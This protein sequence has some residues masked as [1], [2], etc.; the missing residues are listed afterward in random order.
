VRL[1][2][3][4]LIIIVAAPAGAVSPYDL[5]FRSESD[6]M[7]MGGGDVPGDITDRPE[8]ERPTSLL[9]VARP[10]VRLDLCSQTP[11]ELS[12][13]TGTL[14]RWRSEVLTL[15]V[16]KPLNERWAVGIQAKTIDDSVWYEDGPDNYRLHS[17]EE[18]YALSGAYRV[19]RRW[20]VGGAYAWGE[21]DGDARGSAL[22]AALDLAPD[23]EQWPR[24]RLD[25]SNLTLAATFDDGRWS[26]GALRGWSDPR[27]TLRVTRDVYNYT[28]PLDQGADW[29]EIWAGYREGADQ[30]WALMRDRDSSG[31][32]TIMLGAGGRGDTSL[33]LQ[34]RAISAGWR[35]ESGRT[36]TQ[37]QIDRRDSEFATYEQGY[38]GLLPGISADIY[39]LRASGNARIWSLRLGHQR[40]LAGDWSWAAAGGAHFAEVNTD[41]V[42]K[43]V[44]GL[45][46][47]PQVESEA[48]VEDGRVRLWSL[49]LGLLYDSGDFRASLTGTAGIAET[50]AQFADAIAGGG[51]AGGDRLPRNLDVHPLFTVAAEWRR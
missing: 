43:R 21:L 1:P 3:T 26:A 9:G 33:Q 12:D 18:A 34:D 20:S 32:G 23:T 47:S 29:L 35:R 30:W 16:V 40:H 5:F 22:A 19:N 25:D 39:T 49:T 24:L 4:L 46:R 14:G 7:L 44:S 42:L 17:S 10:L 28:A 38:A 51:G 50:N 48:H 27:A 37:A 31:D 8:P 11:V 45:G 13:A 36:I 2:A 41:S 6:S 15:S